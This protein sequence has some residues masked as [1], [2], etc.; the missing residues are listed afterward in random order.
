ME[1]LEY[2]KYF[3]IMWAQVLDT[4]LID[5]EFEQQLIN[6]LA[7]HPSDTNVPALATELSNFIRS[8]WIPRTNDSDSI[9]KTYADSI[10]DYDTWHTL[11]DQVLDIIPF[12]SAGAR[13]IFTTLDKYFYE[14]YFTD[15]DRQELWTEYMN[16]IMETCKGR[17][18]SSE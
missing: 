9:I 18:P 5:T 7:S 3:G 10:H 15:R 1:N 17:D 2:S 16:S 6:V 13:R 4:S 12:R 14:L 11:F 8:P